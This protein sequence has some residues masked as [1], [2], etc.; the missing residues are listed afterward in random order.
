MT[1]VHWPQPQP[2]PST[3]LQGTVEPL[4]FAEYVKAREG[5]ASPAVQKLY[6]T[7]GAY[8]VKPKRASRGLV[9]NNQAFWWSSKGY[10]RPGKAQGRRRPVQHLIWEAHHGRTMPLLHEI[11]F[12]D[13]DRHNF[14]VENL[15]MMHKADLHKRTVALGEVTQLSFEERSKIAGRRWCK[16]SRDVTALLLSRAQSTTT[17]QDHDH[18]S[19]AIR[20]R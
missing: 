10:Y 7:F 15:E 6:D 1:R 18:L 3:P 14:R 13:R 9:W 4:T 2:Q 12:R 8:G 5:K 20:P 16:K 17:K 11:F 19:K